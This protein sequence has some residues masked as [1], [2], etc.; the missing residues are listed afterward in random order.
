ML[1]Y[2]FWQAIGNSVAESDVQ[3]FAWKGACKAYVVSFGMGEKGPGVFKHLVHH[4]VSCFSKPA[5]SR[6][7]EV[8]A[9]TCVNGTSIPPEDTKISK[10]LL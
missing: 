8:R 10:I 1:R 2:I 3:Q 4:P 9:P 5:L 7:L 6:D